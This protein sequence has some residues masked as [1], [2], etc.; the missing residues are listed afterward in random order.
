MLFRSWVFFGALSNVEFEIEV[1]D[2]MTGEQVTYTNPS[3]N[4]G[5]RAD[6]EAFPQPDP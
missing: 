5:S 4:F 1:T 6:T 3:G 2:T